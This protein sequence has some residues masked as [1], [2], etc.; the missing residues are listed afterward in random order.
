MIALVDECWSDETAS[1]TSIVCCVVLVHRLFTMERIRN[2]GK[3]QLF[4]N[5]LFGEE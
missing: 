5:S 4:L 1:L 2:L 3:H